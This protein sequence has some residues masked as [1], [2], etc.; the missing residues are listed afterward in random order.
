MGLPCRILSRAHKLGRIRDSASWALDKGIAWRLLKAMYGARQAW[1]L[2]QDEVARVVTKDG[3]FVKCK[4]V[5]ATYCSEKLDVTVL[6]HGG[7]FLAE[8]TEESLKLGPAA[9]HAARLR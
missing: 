7:D 8:G 6:T 5:P 1:M 2:F 4:A 3:V 9:T